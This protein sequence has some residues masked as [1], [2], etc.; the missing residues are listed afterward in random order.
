A[1]L[2][3]SPEDRGA[4]VTRQWSVLDD[5]RRILSERVPWPV[6]ASQTQNLPLHAALAPGKSGAGDRLLAAKH[7][8]PP[9]RPIAH[10]TKRLQLARADYRQSPGYLIDFDLSGTITNLTMASET[11]FVAGPIVLTGTTTVDS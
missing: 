6:L 3:G 7:D 5:G 2:I 11:I 8:L 4:V 9:S 10:S 1:F